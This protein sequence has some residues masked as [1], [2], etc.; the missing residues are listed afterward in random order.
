MKKP[1]DPLQKRGLASKYGREKCDPQKKGVWALYREVRMANALV[2][3]NF[4]GAI[5]T[6]ETGSPLK[7]ISTRRERL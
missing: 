7:V 6:S 4:A 2:Y 3:L 5:L 1:N